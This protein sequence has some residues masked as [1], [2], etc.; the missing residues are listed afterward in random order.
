MLFEFELAAMAPKRS[1]KGLGKATA[2][3][4]MLTS[5][6]HGRLLLDRDCIQEFISERILGLIR[7][8]SVCGV[9]DERVWD[10][11]YDKIVLDRVTI[12]HI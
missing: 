9:K 8:Y 12:R 10:V 5:L 2:M 1:C 7:I 11:V 6:I 4:I 3:A